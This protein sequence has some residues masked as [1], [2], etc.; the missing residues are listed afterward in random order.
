MGHPA[1]CLE[2]HHGRRKHLYLA[3]C[4]AGVFAALPVA[5]AGSLVSAID[6]AAAA[7][8]TLKAEATGCLWD[9]ACLPAAAAAPSSGGGCA[10]R[11]SAP[12]CGARSAP[13]RRPAAGADGEGRLLAGNVRLTVGSRTAG[14]RLRPA[15][16]RGAL[17]LSTPPWPRL[18]VVKPDDRALTR[19]G[20]PAATCTICGHHSQL[21]GQ[22]GDLGCSCQAPETPQCVLYDC[23][24]ISWKASAGFALMLGSTQI[25]ISCDIIKYIAKGLQSIHPVPTLSRLT[26]V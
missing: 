24:R 18:P 2:C 1:Q 17:G 11:S 22:L 6:A 16:L 7:E 25:V 10:L 21:P 13:P 8:A 26:G 9:T 19:G 12:P 4:R 3:G 23:D 5:L 20:D 15:G 14:L